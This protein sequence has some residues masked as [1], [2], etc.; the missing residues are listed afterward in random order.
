M[1]P[2]TESQSSSKGNSLPDKSHPNAV[3][4][5]PVPKS[6]SQQNAAPTVALP[7]AD[8]KPLYNFALDCQ[9]CQA[10][11]TTAQADLADEKNKFAALTKQRDAALRAA[12]GGSLLRRITRAAKWF[13]LGAAAGAVAAKVTR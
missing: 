11:L 1:T 3:A 5:N 9:A 7:S 10:K 8:L 2:A 12:R 6:S 4:D 13:A